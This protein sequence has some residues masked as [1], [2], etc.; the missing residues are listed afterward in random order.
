M[1]V[2]I[3][4]MSFP[5]PMKKAVSILIYYI[6][7]ILE[8]H[9]TNGDGLLHSFS[10]RS[11]L[12]RPLSRSHVKSYFPGHTAYNRVSNTRLWHSTARTTLAAAFDITSYMFYLR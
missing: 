3:Q 6:D 11:F 2:G 10:N 1:Y 4:I 12:H 7:H 8:D 9:N 5:V